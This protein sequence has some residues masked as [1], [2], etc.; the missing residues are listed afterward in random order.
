MTSFLISSHSQPSTTTSTN[1]KRTLYSTITT[2][3]QFKLPPD[4]IRIILRNLDWHSL[5]SIGK[6]N[7]FFRLLCR[8]TRG[9]G[10]GDDEIWAQHCKL[11]WRG[12]Y[13]RDLPIE[14]NFDSFQHVW[15]ESKRGP[16]DFDPEVELPLMSFEMHFTDPGL[17]LFNPTNGKGL[18]RKF[19]SHGVYWYPPDDAFFQAWQDEQG[20]PRRLPWRSFRDV[21]NIAYVQVADFPPMAALRDTK[22]WQWVF[23]GRWTIYRSVSTSNMI[24]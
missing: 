2:S 14:Y 17:I 23:I 7:K 18:Q 24:L 16:T 5:I 10:E 19:L 21:S 1:S 8:G 15:I 4:I 9:K 11:E 12:K 20:G 22:T 6:V 13:I 3:I